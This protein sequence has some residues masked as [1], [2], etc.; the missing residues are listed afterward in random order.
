MDYRKQGKP[1]LAPAS[2]PSFSGHGKKKARTLLSE[3]EELAEH[4]A[5]ASVSRDIA[6]VKRHLVSAM[7]CLGRHTLTGHI[8]TAGRQFVD[9]SA[10]YRL[11]AKARVDTYALFSPVRQTI[12]R[13]LPAQAPVVIAIDDTR[14]KKSSKKTPG[15]RYTRDPLGPPFRVNLILAQ[16]FVQFSMA[17]PNDKG[18]ARM[19]PIDFMHA[20]N[21]QKPGKNSTADDWKAYRETAFI[22]ALPRV[23]Q[24]RLHTLRQSLDDDG[25]KNRKLFAVV[26]GGYTNRTF[27]KNIPERTCIIG[28]IRGDAKLYYLPKP[29]QGRGHPRVYGEQAPTPEQLRQD[30]RTPWTHVK[31]WAC[32]KHHHFRVKTIGPVR[33]RATGKS[34]DLRIVVIAPL[35]Y[36]IR[37]K[38]KMLYR[39]PAYLICTTPEVP[40]QQILQ[41]Y[42][43]RWDIEVNF[44]D[45]KTVLGI[46]QAQV[47]ND[48]S[49]D[50][51][52]ALNVAAYAILLTAATNLYGIEAH[53]LSLAPPKW[54]Q[55]KKG[56]VST[57]KLIAQLRNDLWGN[58]INSTHFELHTDKNTKSNQILPGLHGALFYGASNI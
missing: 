9:W 28:R 22:Q 39:K 2:G 47:H 7:V 37:Q 10:D 6:R 53:E 4:C 27:L 25:Q 30:E 19:I 18:A 17:W 16:R 57:Q 51:V 49:V 41:H 24:Q 42:L 56:R 50:K 15:V 35:A 13:N 48:N 21:A 5:R 58:A 31:A 26:D 23:A 20:P 3:I 43:W 40:L 52:P 29:S 32:G 54:Q 33:W 38:G 46:G 55:I 34:H 12:A 36:R 1:D 45:E 44:R 8:A 11:Y 14:L